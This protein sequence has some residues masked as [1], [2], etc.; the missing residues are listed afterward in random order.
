MVNDIFAMNICLCCDLSEHNNTVSL[1]LSNGAKID[2]AENNGV[3]PLYIA[4]QFGHKD[5]VLLLL[6]YGATMN[7]ANNVPKK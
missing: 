1:L 7:Q 5:T 6:S 4:A 3:T 2:Q